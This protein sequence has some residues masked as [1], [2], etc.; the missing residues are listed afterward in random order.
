[1]GQTLCEIK[2]E[3][4]SSS[5]EENLSE[6]K[7]DVDPL[8]LEQER[9]SGFKTMQMEEPPEIV[10]A[11]DMSEQPEKQ[12]E[13]RSASTGSSSALQNDTFSDLA[14]GQSLSAAQDP[15]MEAGGGFKFSGEGS[16]LSSASSSSSS[17][18]HASSSSEPVPELSR[19]SDDPRRPPVNNNEV[20]SHREGGGGRGLSEVWH[21]RGSSDVGDKNGGEGQKGLVRRRLS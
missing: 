11:E 10:K 20:L 18:S 1:M 2:T 3:Q 12:A 21:I 5:V 14:S 7:A 15:A 19:A 4:K 13:T 8:P 6:T 17:S 16:I 9:G